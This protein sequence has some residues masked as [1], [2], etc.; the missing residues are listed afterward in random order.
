MKEKLFAGFRK[1]EKLVTIING[2]L[3][4]FITLIILVQVVVRKLGISL[5]GT[6]ELARFSY[7]I[8][9]FL[10]WP[11]ACLYGSNISITLLLDKLPKKFRLWVL[12]FFQVAM[13]FF[14]GIAA[15]SAW[16]Q[17]KNQKGVLA[18]SNDW[19]HM[20]WL[21]I[22]VFVCLVLCVLF[23]LFRAVFLVTGDME[24]KTQDEINEELI[25]NS[26]KLMEEMEGKI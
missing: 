26:K 2:V 8:Y 15:K 25:E 6:E 18:P 1:L 20:E 24:C 21:Y 12:V 14:S 5:A 23:N 22:V 4:I 13:A 19:F 16:L 10:A 11:I 7:V 9:T 3:L 17:M